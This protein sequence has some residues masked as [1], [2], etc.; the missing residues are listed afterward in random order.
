V[1]DN[2]TAKGSLVLMLVM[3]TLRASVMPPQPTC[4]RK[5]RDAERKRK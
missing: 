5:T 3:A 4:V 1:P 2:V